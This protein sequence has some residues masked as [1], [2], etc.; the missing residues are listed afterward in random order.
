MATGDLSD[1]PHTRPRPA[2]ACYA[3]GTRLRLQRHAGHRRRHLHG[4]DPGG[5]RHAGPARRARPL[6]AGRLDDAAA[7][8][9]GGSMIAASVGSAVYEACLAARA[10]L[11]ELVRGDSASPLAHAT[12][13]DVEAVDGRLSSADDPSRGE[14]LRRHPA[15]ARAR[16]R[17]RS[18]AHSRARARAAIRRTPSARASPRC[19]WTRTR[20]GPRDALR[21]RDLRRA[22]PERQA[23]RSQLIGGTMIG[24]GMALLEHTVMD[25]RYGRVRQP[26]LCRLSRAR[27]RRRARPSRRSW[28]TR[29]DPHVNPLGVKGIGELGRRGRRPGHRQRRLPRHRRPHP[30]PADHAGQAA[31]VAHQ[32]AG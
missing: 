26:E 17:S 15:A 10:R 28:S 12:S 4:D 30:R 5:R 23:A 9:E 31:L 21:E 14:S 24:L 2:C 18:L 29:S 27:P 7:P 19:A 32:P 11:L 6:R 20:R 25:A 8:S 22:H 3:D 1:A 16:P 13:D